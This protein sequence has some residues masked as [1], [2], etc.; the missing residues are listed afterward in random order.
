MAAALNILLSLSLALVVTILIVLILM[1]QP[2]MRQGITFYSPV[3]FLL[4]ATVGLWSQA[5]GMTQGAG[6][7]I[8]AAVAGLIVLL[9]ALAVRPRQPRLRLL[10]SG[11]DSEPR[12]L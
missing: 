2:G 10:T 9:T 3:M 5:S 6:R 1:R 4:V 11:S 8:A 7:W 12:R